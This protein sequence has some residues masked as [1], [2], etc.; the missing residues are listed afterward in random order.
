L[1]KEQIAEYLEIIYMY[2]DIDRE[3]QMMNTYYGDILFK[4]Q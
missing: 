2:G 1:T 3:F 4:K